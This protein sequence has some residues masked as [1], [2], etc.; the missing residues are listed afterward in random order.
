MLKKLLVFGIGGYAMKKA[1]EAVNFIKDVYP[2][3]K[4]LDS[5]L[6]GNNKQVFEQSVKIFGRELINNYGWNIA[7]ADRFTDLELME[8]N[9]MMAA[10]GNIDLAR[11]MTLAIAN[12]ETKTIKMSGENFGLILKFIPEIF[13]KLYI[14]T[15]VAHECRH[16]HQAEWL[17]EKVGTNG[18]IET[19]MKINSTMTYK[20]N[21]LEVDARYYE[22]H[23]SGPSFAEVFK[24]YI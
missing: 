21:I 2:K 14:A 22:Y 24:G 11:A 19:F 9:S 3:M 5:K 7:W 13:R 1:I 8:T 17:R 16:A 18:M 15:T 10:G 23:L 4:D 20:D 12:P 6:E